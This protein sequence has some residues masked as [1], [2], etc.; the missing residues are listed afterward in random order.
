MVL[1]SAD[2]DALDALLNAN[3]E[4]TLDSKPVEL[5]ASVGNLHRGI[6]VRGNIDDACT[7][8]EH[9]ANLK[10]YEANCQ[11]RN[12][13]H[14]VCF[15]EGHIPHDCFYMKGYGVHMITGEVNY[16]SQDSYE[17]ALAA[18][19]E[20][21][22]T[23]FG[24]INAH[25]VEFRDFGK[26]SMKHRGFV[27]N[28]FS[29]T[30]PGE[31]NVTNVIDKCVFRHSWQDGIVISRAPAVT[32]TNNIVHRTLG[33]GIST[34]DRFINWGEG[35]RAARSMV[36]S[37]EIPN[38]GLHTIDGNLVS[39]SFWYPFEDTDSSV[40]THHWH[41]GMA[42]RHEMASFKDN[43]VAGA[44]HAGMTF[45]IQ[46]A[47]NLKVGEHTVD[48]NEAYGARYGAVALNQVQGE[49]RELY[50]FK[51]WKNVRAGIV[52]FDETS[53][54]QIRKAVLSDNKFGVGISFV[55]SASLRVVEST[56]IGT[57][58]AT[59]GCPGYRIGVMLPRYGVIARCEG[60]FGPCKDCS[61]EGNAMDMRFGNTHTGRE[62]HF[63][64]EATKF[65][66]FGDNAECGAD[67]SLAVAINPDENDYT[68]ETWLSQ[69]TWLP[70]VAKTSR[71]QLGAVKNAHSDCGDDASC[72]AVNYMKF[73]DVDGST[74]GDK[75]AGKIMYS[76]RNPAATVEPKCKADTD[77][78][79]IICKNYDPPVMEVH[80]PPPCNDG[81]EPPRFITVHKYGAA[82]L[83]GAQ[84]KRTFWTMGAFE[85][86]CSCQKHFMGGSFP[87]EAGKDLIYDVEM[88]IED[89]LNKPGEFEP[90]WIPPNTKFVYHSQDPTECV[91]LRLRMLTANPVMLML[92]GESMDS[93]K[94]T[95]GSFPTV[96]SNPG[97]N[98][99]DP[100]AR[101][102]FMT[103]CGAPGGK[104]TYVLRVKEAVQVTMEI[105]MSLAEFFAE[106]IPTQQEID[107]AGGSVGL[108]QRTTGLDRLVNNFAMLLDIPSSKIKVVC[109][110]KPGEP[111]IPDELA[112]LLGGFNVGGRR[113]SR[114]A[115]DS[116]AY[117]VEMEIVP[118]NSVEETGDD[119][120]Y[121][122]NLDF[123]EQVQSKLD[124]VTAEATFAGDL[125]SNI[126]GATV[127]GVSVA[128]AFGSD[129][130]KDDIAVTS[131]GQV[132][133][134]AGD[135]SN[136]DGAGDGVGPS[137]GGNGNSTGNSNDDDSGDGDGGISG[138]TGSLSPGGAAAVAITVI[139]AVALI[140]FMYMRHKKQ[141]HVVTATKVISEPAG[142][143]KVDVE[144]VDFG[145][146]QFAETSMDNGHMAVQ[147]PQ[148]YVARAQMQRDSILS[149][150]GEL[151]VLR[152]PATSVHE[153]QQR[154][155]SLRRSSVQLEGGG[156]SVPGG[157]QVFVLNGGTMQRRSSQV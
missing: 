48:N 133:G 53:D 105:E 156:V 26:L 135:G 7:A 154:R 91:L 88:P 29:D 76:D 100:Q 30:A 118:P 49:A 109:I 73:H 70:S 4:V 14:H 115:G 142:A 77:T 99:L 13:P 39:D 47:Q 94:L 52:G 10:A 69:I 18:G 41:S 110:H 126:D 139:A 147:M 87:A 27:I 8:E 92:N 65:A 22:P 1:S 17:D 101:K 74:I 98:V 11:Q 61:I 132:S 19:E 120:L 124:E 20:L 128:A 140:V 125:V 43:V 134:S 5:R 37:N 64:I 129:A 114:R 6:V 102:F 104:A 21:P 16:G 50:N 127:V 42:L 80:V 95:D 137:N 89:A 55:P 150:F 117:Q 97:T 34:G 44:A 60:T 2:G 155:S 23:Q 116:G 71:M 32:L 151:A 31:N 145:R 28:Y 25:G 113:R 38:G 45:R 3:V 79:S 82:G 85:Q 108:V 136:G 84:E 68:P 56:V 46:D 138:S 81:C 24:Q 112:A 96:S 144:G 36:V 130:A 157:E 103:A 63:Y 9:A 54:I 58:D 131:V 152:G 123:L 86:G 51:A 121:A 90:E 106:E 40:K 59:V 62:E 78:G 75:N 33:V 93:N 15:E 153:Q 148:E 111:C 122:Q 83:N 143:F 67:D 66:H 12:K 141:P 57:S 149:E 119:E 146:P 107:A 35:R 72:D